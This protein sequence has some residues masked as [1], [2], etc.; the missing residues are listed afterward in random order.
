MSG[1]CEGLRFG[2]RSGVEEKGGC[3]RLVDGSM[4]QKDVEKAR[5]FQ[6]T[7]ANFR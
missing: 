4:V 5:W 6:D 1:D 7:C 2:G 3:L